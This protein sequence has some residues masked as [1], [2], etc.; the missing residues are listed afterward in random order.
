VEL[1]RFVADD[2][3][4]A[5]LTPAPQAQGRLAGVALAW[6]GAT[7]FGVLLV[8][9]LAL[10]MATFG[11]PATG[12]D[13]QWYLVV[14]DRM[15][16]GALPY[17]DLFDRKPIGLFLIFA[18]IRGLGGAGIWQYQ[19][20][21]CSVVAATAWCIATAAKAQASG[22][23]AMLCAIGYIAW[24][25]IMEGEGAQAELFVN[26][27]MAAAALLIASRRA[28]WLAMLLAGCA[29]QIKTSAVFEAA[30]FGIAALIATHPFEWRRAC[31][32]ALLGAV[33]T[34]AA[35]AGYAVTG[36]ADAWWFAN[37]TS[38]ALQQGD[39][40][41]DGA[42]GLAAIVAILTPV[43]IA[44][45]RGTRDWFWRGW[46]LV[47]LTA[48]L[49]FARFGSPHYAIPAIVPLLVCAAPFV[50]RWWRTSIAMVGGVALGG[51]LLLATA[52]LRKGDAATVAAMT[53]VIVHQ[54]GCLFI[55]DGYPILYLTTHKCMATRF[56]FPSHLS[57]GKER[58]ALG[59]DA[60]DE[61][62]RV[63]A[64]RPGAIVDDWPRFDQQDRVERAMLDA[65]L[66]RH[67]RL[68]QV[69]THGGRRRLVY[70]LA[71]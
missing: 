2:M 6:P 44:A 40:L 5:Q 24:L 23:A 22:R 15:L 62:R 14:G 16:S 27:L 47:A 59:I 37:V 30:W 21:A 34:L 57:I 70:V 64:S 13:E 71:H 49:G 46:A 69:V 50:D 54:P 61:L 43:V 42:I 32:W 31:G 8:I 48:L 45:T 12:F 17:V 55:F 33:P 4:Q 7:R 18:A 28:L 9:A 25:N 66:A 36:H 41:R 29:I 11:N 3:A 1:R 38:V 52:P 68:A 51:Q 20:V 60:R 10:R 67:Y 53:S 26:V 63:L 39:T 56:A 35:I 19:L 65:T 58:N